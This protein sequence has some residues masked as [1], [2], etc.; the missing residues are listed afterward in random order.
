MSLSDR[1]EIVNH[2]AREIYG[3]IS[4]VEAVDPSIL[5]SAAFLNLPLFV[6]ACAFIQDFRIRT[7]RQV[8]Q[9]QVVNAQSA[10][11]QGVLANVAA[12]NF[13]LLRNTLQL[14]AERWH[15]V[16]WVRSVLEKRGLN[17]TKLSLKEML[18]ECYTFV[19]IFCRDKL[20]TDIDRR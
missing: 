12:T 14:I 9:N 8:S 1:M 18:D 6:A 10:G 16:S 15:G 13:S 7:G 20:S 5:W 3:M 19:S 11:M 17:N 2:S 4:M